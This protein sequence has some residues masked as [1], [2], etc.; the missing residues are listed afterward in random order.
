MTMMDKSKAVGAQVTKRMGRPKNADMP[1]ISYHDLDR[2]LVFGEMVDDGDGFGPVTRY[3][4][5]RELAAR[6]GVSHSLIAAYASKHQCLHRREVARQRLD[7]RTDEKL[8]EK[9]AS[10]IADCSVKIG[11][12]I[13]GFITEF[14]KA[15]AEGRVRSDS[16][17]DFN[18]M[19]RLKEYLQGGADS[20]VETRS[21]LSL[22]S[23]QARHARMLANRSDD[24]ALSGV[25][26][27]DPSRHDDEHLVNG[28]PP[29]PPSMPV[30]R[31]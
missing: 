13:E 3:P 24:A 28:R 1:R 18:M 17:S 8:I 5:Y 15:L 21:V 7:A 10:D 2:L 23:L 14:K 27:P 6:Y 9:R 29:S 31:M 26:L 20:R 25:V 16:V 22:E 19:V 4:S 11:D 12:I 30:A